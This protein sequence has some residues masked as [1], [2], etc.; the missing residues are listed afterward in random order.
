[1][2]PPRTCGRPTK[3]GTPCTR[4]LQPWEQACCTHAT[5]AEQEVEYQILKAQQ[6][7]RR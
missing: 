3:H 6:Q 7:A 5:A 4:V 1:M 2:T